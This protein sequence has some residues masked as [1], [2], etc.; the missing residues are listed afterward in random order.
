[1]TCIVYNY[2]MMKKIN[3]SKLARDLRV[4]PRHINRIFR[5][6]QKPSV[7]LAQE[8]QKHTDIP[9]TSWFESLGDYLPE[10]SKQEP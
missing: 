3:Q 9:W 1:M 10:T 5:R 2:L 8:I 4:T 7:K 6:K